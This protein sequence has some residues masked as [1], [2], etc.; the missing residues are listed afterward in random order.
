MD[1][2]KERLEQAA[3]SL[4]ELIAGLSP[5]QESEN[6]RLRGKREGVQLALS[7]LYEQERR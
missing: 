5:E 3:V 2:L 1:E 4:T 7:Y 6:T